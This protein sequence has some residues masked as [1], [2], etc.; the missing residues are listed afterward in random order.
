[1]QGSHRFVRVTFKPEAI[2]SAKSLMLDDP[3][4]SSTRLGRFLVGYA[5]DRQGQ[6]TDTLH[7][8]DVNAIKSA[9]EYRE[10]L[11]YGTLE[12]KQ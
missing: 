12:R 10:N 4:E 8:C 5:C 1:M 2:T 7:M 9:V 6:R 11:K 3:K